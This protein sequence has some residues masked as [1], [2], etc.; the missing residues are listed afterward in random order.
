M[1]I[2]IILPILAAVAV[3]AWLYL[4]RSRRKGKILLRS[5]VRMPTKPTKPTKD[6]P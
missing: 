6:Q 4:S 3:L 1:T 2:F 5:P